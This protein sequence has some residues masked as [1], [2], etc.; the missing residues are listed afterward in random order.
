MKLCSKVRKFLGILRSYSVVDCCDGVVL[1]AQRKT[2][3][4]ILGQ[5]HG[6]ILSRGVHP[7]ALGTFLEIVPQLENLMKFNCRNPM[8]QTVTSST[9]LAT[10]SISN[11]M[12]CLKICSPFRS[13]LLT[14]PS[15]RLRNAPLR[16]KLILRRDS[17]RN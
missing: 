4:E 3:S 12:A 16:E 9:V 1:E 11:G 6:V 14:R 7:S 15:T 8:W 5:L 2:R 10:S 13:P 17:R